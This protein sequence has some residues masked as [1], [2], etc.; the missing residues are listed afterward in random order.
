MQCV[1]RGSES[2]CIYERF[3]PSKYVRNLDLRTRA[4][5]TRTLK[6]QEQDQQADHQKHLRVV[7]QQFAMRL[8]QKRQFCYDM[9]KVMVT[10]TQMFLD[11]WGCWQRYALVIMVFPIE[12]IWHWTGHRWH[13]C[14]HIFPAWSRVEN[15]EQNSLTVLRLC[16]TITAQTASWNTLADILSSS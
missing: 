15:S 5:L 6:D 7:K 9:L 11:P 12:Q 14:R 3:K 16:E 2:I 10:Q 8:I 13:R 1:A 4:V